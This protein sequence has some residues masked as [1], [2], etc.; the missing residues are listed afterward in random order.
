MPLIKSLGNGAGFIDTADDS[1]LLLPNG[2][3]LQA[4][5]D[6]NKLPYITATLNGRSMQ[7]KCHVTVKLNTER[8]T[9]KVQ[10]TARELQTKHEQMGHIHYQGVLDILGATCSE[11]LPAC[12]CY[13]Q[14]HRKENVATETEGEFKERKHGSVYFSDIHGPMPTASGGYN[15]ILAMYDPTAPHTSYSVPIKGKNGAAEGFT[16]LLQQVKARGLDIGPGSKTPVV[17][18]ADN[19]K[20]EFRSNAMIKC[21]TDNNLVLRCVAPETPEKNRC[22]RLW[23]YLLPKMK[24]CMSMVP[25]SLVSGHGHLP[26]LNTSCSPSLNERGKRARKSNWRK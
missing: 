13:E 1:Y 11:P 20:G 25:Q 16:K 7:P 17:I 3:K 12:P 15:Y 19:G 8:K 9:P 24:A 6:S 26:T 23:G 4:R 14:N 2:Q 10:I 22:E 21:F 5:V 18:V